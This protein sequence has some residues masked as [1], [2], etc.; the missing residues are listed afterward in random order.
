MVF[1]KLKTWLHTA[2]AYIREVLE[3]VIVASDGWLTKQDAKTR[4]GHHG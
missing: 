3:D 1:S 2:Q 4:F